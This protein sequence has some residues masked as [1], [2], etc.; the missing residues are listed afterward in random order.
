MI[1]L[2]SPYTDPDPKIMQLRYDLVCEACAGLARK[3][4]VVYSPIMHW[5]PVAVAHDLP[6]DHLFWGIQNYGMISCCFVF[7]ILTLDGWKVSAGIKSD[8][9]YAEKLGKNIKKNLA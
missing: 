1:Y 9:E 3:K 7:Y 2:A 8:T 6:R 5:H 4:K